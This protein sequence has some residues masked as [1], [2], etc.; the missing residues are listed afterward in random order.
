MIALN[1][2][3][4]IKALRKQNNLSQEQL[5]EKLNVSRQ[6]VS[7]W[8]S[9]TAYPDIS[10]LILLRDIFGV[11]LDYLVIDNNTIENQDI[12]EDK[13][14][15][16]KKTEARQVLTDFF[17]AMKEHK[18]KDP[19]KYCTD[20]LKNGSYSNVKDAKIIE[21]KDDIDKKSRFAYSLNRGTITNPY[22]VICFE[23]TYD[24]QYVDDKVSTEASG[25]VTK[26]FTLIKETETSPWLIDEWGY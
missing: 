2:G 6:A 18:T 24:M 7:K 22:D 4:R 16:N 8:E 21:I 1:L 20:N 17:A 19:S 11:T 15:D 5:A 9:N 10:N 13:S 14:A 26:W 25:I 3:E 12:N 23:V